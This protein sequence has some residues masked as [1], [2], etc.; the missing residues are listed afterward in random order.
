MIKLLIWK[1][2]RGFKAYTHPGHAALAITDGNNVEHYVSWWPEDVDKDEDKRRG[3]Q[4]GGTNSLLND[5]VMEM[6]DN[7]RA[8]LRSGAVPRAGQ[9]KSENIVEDGFTV[10]NQYAQWVKRPDETLTIPSVDDRSHPDRASIGLC[11]KNIEDWWTLFSEKRVGYFA[12]RYKMISKDFNCASVVMLAL[13][14]GGCDI[15]L[16]HDRACFYYLPNEIMNY[17][18]RLSDRI[19]EINDQAQTVNASLLANHARISP[20]SRSQFGSC[21]PDGTGDIWSATAWRMESAVRIGRRKEQISQIDHLI[22]EYWAAGPVWN[23]ANKVEKSVKL[24][25][26]LRQVQSHIVEK[27]KSDRRESV[28]KLGSQCI[29]VLKDRTESNPDWKTMIKQNVGVNF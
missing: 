8:R 22:Q 18:R 25:E 26:I 13:I 10:N 27:P 23:D 2:A 19:R 16:K 24:R 7:A 14:A 29:L 5:Y 1:N 20:G 12:Q 9:T 15:F 6:G 21:N 17:G 3:Y 4:K 28:L 11:E